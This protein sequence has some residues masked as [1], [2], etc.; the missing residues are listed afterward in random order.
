MIS[1][2]DAITAVQ[3]ALDD[4]KIRLLHSP[5]YGVYIHADEQLKIMLDMLV[6]DPLPPESERAFV[7]IGIMAVKELE[8]EEPEY[9]DALMLASYSFKNAEVS[10]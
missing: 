7:D 1:R 3:T 10:T 9:A 8:A 6:L 5:T 4:T 2:Q